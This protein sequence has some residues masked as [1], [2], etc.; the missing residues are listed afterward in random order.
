MGRRHL[1]FGERQW[2]KSGKGGIPGNCGK[3]MET[4]EG[5]KETVDGR[6]ETVDERNE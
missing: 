2:G 4:G 5:R 3:F 6:K 1:G